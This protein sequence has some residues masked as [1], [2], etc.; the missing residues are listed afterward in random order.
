[1]VFLLTG[2]YDL[3]NFDSD[4]EGENYSSTGNIQ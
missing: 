1:M 4:E 2:A 3:L